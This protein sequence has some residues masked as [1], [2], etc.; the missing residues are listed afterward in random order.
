MSQASRGPRPLS[1]VAENVARVQSNPHSEF[2]GKL[3]AL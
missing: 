3:G 2:E 1:G